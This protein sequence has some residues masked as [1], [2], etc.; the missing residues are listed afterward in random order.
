MQFLSGPLAWALLT[1]TG[2]L[3]HPI[4]RKEASKAL[5][6]KGREPA[7]HLGPHTCFAVVL[8]LPCPGMGTGPACSASFLDSPSALG[9]LLPNPEKKSSSSVGCSRGDLKGQGPLLYTGYTSHSKANRE[10]QG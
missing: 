7:Q 1:S 4:W 5:P 6:R 10:T 8:A 2:K 9:P 3:T